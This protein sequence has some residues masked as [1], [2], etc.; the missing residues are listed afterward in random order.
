M[1]VCVCRCIDMYVCARVYDYVIP[2][3]MNFKIKV[4][5]QQYI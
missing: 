4:D 2:A 3:M 5:F 1:C